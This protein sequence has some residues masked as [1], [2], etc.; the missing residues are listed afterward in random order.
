MSEHA[1]QAALFQWA[2]IEGKQ[3][4]I[5]NLLF[6][7]PNGGLRSYITAARLKEEGV[8][9]GV[10]DIFFP[11]ARGDYHGLFIEMKYG[12]NK[13]TAEQRA[14]EK[15]LRQGGY[16][17]ALCRNWSDAVEVVEWYLDGKHDNKT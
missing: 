3:R 15:E 12:R 17:C 1:H 8:K 2:A 11:V 4:P 13:Q 7:I 6:A 9:A 5:L 10:P 16:A 14:W